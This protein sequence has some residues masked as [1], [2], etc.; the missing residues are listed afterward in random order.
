VEREIPFH[1]FAFWNEYSR[2]SSQ[3]QYL[4]IYTNIHCYV[5]ILS[6]S[7]KNRPF[8]FYVYGLFQVYCTFQFAKLTAN[9]TEIALLSVLFHCW[10]QWQF[11]RNLFDNYT[12]KG[13][14]FSLENVLL[15][16]TVFFF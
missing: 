10:Q 6:L 12:N 7:S 13:P 8:G 11:S 4:L 3:N 14:N 2:I 5:S 15:L 16:I 9:G 1:A